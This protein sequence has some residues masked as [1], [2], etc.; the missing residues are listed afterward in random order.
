MDERSDYRQPIPSKI[1][2]ATGIGSGLPIHQTTGWN[3]QEPITTHEPGESSRPSGAHDFASIRQA[4]RAASSS[5]DESSDA[6]AANLV[7]VSAS[8]WDETSADREVLRVKLAWAKLMWLMAFLMVL[9]AVS[10]LVPFIAENTQYAI[11]RGKQRAEYDFA[12]QHLAGDPLAQMSQAYQM[13]SQRV[14]P[15]VV[16]IN[17]IA[18]GS[19]VYLPTLSLQ[20]PSRSRMPAEGQGSGFIVDAGG[21]V[22]TN[23]HVI[24]DAQRIQVALSD[25]RRVEGQI[26]GYDK[27]TDLAVLKIKAD[28]LIA[29]Q[30]ANSDDV[31]VGSLVWAVGSP[32]GLERS[33]TSGILSAKHR[34]GLAGTPYQDFLQSDAAVNPG[35]SGG[36]LVDIQGR[37]LGVNTAIVG[38]AYQGISF[39]VPSNVAREV[40]ERL[41]DDGLVRRGWL[42]VALDVPDR[43]EAIKAGSTEGNGALVSQVVDGDGM[44]SPA[45]KAGIE[46]G[47]IVIR[48]NDTPVDAPATLSNLVARTPVGSTASVVIARGGQ[49]STVEVVVG[50]RPS[51]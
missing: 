41:R 24:R 32:F 20:S 34:A 45:A 9:L 47:D 26:I 49:Q 40:F 4:V 44:Q 46:S 12:K 28:K 8:P 42:G 5:P 21:Y 10:Y 33:I 14:S 22:V 15:S 35:N 13:V 16:H 31:N 50:L 51:P 38:D 39:A 3:T 37:V 6:A 18:S 25:G 43:E 29:A 11:T 36:P 27:E 1:P 2:P 48:W 30:W 19:D 23:Y 17:T 7:G